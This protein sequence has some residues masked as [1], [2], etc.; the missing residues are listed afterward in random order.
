MHL[1]CIRIGLKY[2]TNENI[3]FK[4]RIWCIRVV[5]QHLTDETND[6]YRRFLSA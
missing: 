5:L 4:M 2:L 3:R 6:H 1:G